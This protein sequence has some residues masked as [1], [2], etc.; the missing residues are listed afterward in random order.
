MIPSSQATKLF[1]NCEIQQW[2]R[3]VNKYAKLLNDAWKKEIHPRI[4]HF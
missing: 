2:F 4:V 3:K 1:L